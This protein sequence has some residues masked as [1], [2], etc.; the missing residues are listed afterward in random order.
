MI[1]VHNIIKPPD[2]HVMIAMRT[3]THKRHR[4][5][6]PHTTKFPAKRREAKNTHMHETTEQ[7]TAHSEH[8]QQPQQ[9]QQR[10]ISE[11]D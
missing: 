5:A 9:Q 8:S 6:P 11:N 4:Q 10:E 2:T 1:I 7:A 3:S